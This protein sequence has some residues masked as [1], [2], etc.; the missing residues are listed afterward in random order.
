MCSWDAESEPPL[1]WAGRFHELLQA[2]VLTETLLLLVL[3][4]QSKHTPFSPKHWQYFPLPCPNEV[5]PAEAA[6][7]CHPAFLP[8][9]SDVVFQ[10]NSVPIC[11]SSVFCL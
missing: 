4:G 2:S 11:W 8:Y 1:A 5:T 7:L 9:P 6:A 10:S 3:Q